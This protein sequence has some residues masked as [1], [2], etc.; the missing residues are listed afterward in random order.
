MDNIIKKSLIILLLGII[1][2]ENCSRCHPVWMVI[3]PF[4]FTAN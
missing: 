3:H 4:R 1:R 2:D